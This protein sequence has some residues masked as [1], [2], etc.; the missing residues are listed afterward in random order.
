MNSESKIDFTATVCDRCVKVSEKAANVWVEIDGVRIQIMRGG[1]DAEPEVCIDA[2]ASETLD[3]GK[4]EPLATVSVPASRPRAM[5][6]EK[7][8]KYR[9]VRAGA[10]LS[11]YRPTAPYCQEGWSRSLE[12]GE[13]I[14]CAGD[15]MTFGDGVPAIK[16]LDANGKWIANDCLF[17]PVKGGMWGGQV[18]ADGFLE[19]A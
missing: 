11:G 16:W 6:Y 8:K 18:P 15:S 9:V 10:R 17:H 12:V 7:G 5:K 2:W 14:T 13:V 4:G 1:T 3:A 19:D